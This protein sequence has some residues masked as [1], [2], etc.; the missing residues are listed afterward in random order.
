MLPCLFW[1]LC[2]RH[3]HRPGLRNFA[4]DTAGS[5]VF[6]PSVHHSMGDP[7]SMVCSC[8][9]VESTQQQITM[10]DTLTVCSWNFFALRFLLSLFESWR[11]TW[12]DTLYL[13]HCSFGFCSRFY[14][15]SVNESIVFS[16]APF[17]IHHW[18][19]IRRRRG[20]ECHWHSCVQSA[21]EGIAHTCEAATK[22]AAN[23]WKLLAR[24][25]IL[26]NPY[27]VLS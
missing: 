19:R 6:H 15:F 14:S 26:S 7:G 8:G 12:C 4:R 24:S 9:D 20:I 22:P 23:G 25:D 21:S 17:S 2:H 3:S 11:I 10:I 27:E 18:V 5:F 13:I 16:C 1:L